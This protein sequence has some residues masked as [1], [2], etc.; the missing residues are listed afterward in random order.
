MH[1]CVRMRCALRSLFILSLFLVLATAKVFAERLMAGWDPF[2]VAEEEGLLKQLNSLPQFNAKSWLKEGASSR[3]GKPTVPV[4]TQVVVNVPTATGERRFVLYVPDSY[5]QNGNSTAALQ[6]YFHGLNDQCDRFLNAINVIEHA[7]KT[8]FV[9]ASLCGSEGAIGT[10]WNAGTCC[11]F[12]SEKQPDD[13]DFAEKV[14]ESV[15]ASLGVHFTRVMAVGFS[16]GAMMAEGLGCRKPKLIRAV[17]SVGGVV[18]LRPG[19]EAGLNECSRALRTDNEEGYRP[20]VL[21]VHGNLDVV[22]PMDGD[23]FLGFPPLDANLRSWAESNGCKKAPKTLNTSNYETRVYTDCTSVSDEFDSRMK[24]Y[25]IRAKSA[26]KEGLNGQKIS[27]AR[28]SIVEFVLALQ[29]G[30]SWPSDKE[31]STTEHIFDFA[32]RVFFSV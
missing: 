4:N 1:L 6:L 8:G 3:G 17:V 19:N 24:S 25:W 10:A 30:H 31:F 29:E 28:Q 11:G 23:R 15:S 12:F 13:F 18:V 20:S 32:Q 2:A 16:N 26:I 27:S 5:M 9:L 14:V 7:K 22:V 21:M